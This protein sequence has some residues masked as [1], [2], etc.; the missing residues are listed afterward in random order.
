MCCEC[1]SQQEKDF[2]SS[3]EHCLARYSNPHKLI[4]NNDDTHATNQSRVQQVQFIWWA[5]ND[6]NN[7]SLNEILLFARFQTQALALTRPKSPKKDESGSPPSSVRPNDNLRSPIAE[8]PHS[9]PN[10]KTP[11][12][13]N[14]SSEQHN[15]ALELN[16]SNSNANSNSKVSPSPLSSSEKSNHHNDNM[17]I[18]NGVSGSNHSQPFSSHSMNGPEKILP[19]P[20]IDRKDFDF[21]KVNGEST[22]FFDYFKVLTFDTIK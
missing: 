20:S 5:F 7:F 19:S 12:H 22:E 21:S 16:S 3:S 4:S 18:N 1:I 9:R 14:S 2:D 10:S 6:V 15:S 17:S 8:A 13:C 11:V